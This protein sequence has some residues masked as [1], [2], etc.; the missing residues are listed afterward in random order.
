V[1]SR[2]EFCPKTRPEDQ[3]GLSRTGGAPAVAEP[4][5]EVSVR[6]PSRRL[7]LEKRL[8]EVNVTRCRR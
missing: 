5:P 3:T 2:T 1:P 8:F 7:H 4:A 6:Q